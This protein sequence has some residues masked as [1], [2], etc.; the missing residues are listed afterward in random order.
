MI[1]RSKWIPI[2]VWIHRTKN[3]PTTISCDSALVRRALQRGGAAEPAR[4]PKPD[5]RTLN[6]SA[7]PLLADRAQRDGGAAR[8]GG[9]AAPH[10]GG[11]RQRTGHRLPT[12]G[13]RVRGSRHGGDGWRRHL[14]RP[15]A[16]AHGARIVI[17]TQA[18]APAEAAVSL[19]CYKYNTGAF[20]PTRC[21]VSSLQV[22]QFIDCAVPSVCIPEDHVANYFITITSEVTISRIFCYSHTRSVNEELD[23]Y[24]CRYFLEAWH[25]K[26]LISIQQQ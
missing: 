24:I 7:P 9:G 8:P 5:V 23:N 20:G 17:L 4:A 6:R 2:V 14:H 13:P 22:M 25:R 21:S 18:R 10:G 19:V 26:Y 3:R 11:G 16:P 12:G 15:A 1:V